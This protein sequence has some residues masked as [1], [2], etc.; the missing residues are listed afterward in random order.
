[1]KPIVMSCDTSG[2]RIPQPYLRVY[3]FTRVVF[4]VSSSPFLLSATI[5]FHLEKYL[6]TSECLVRHLLHSTYVDDILSGG[7][8]KDEAFN[9]YTA[10]KIFCEEGF[11]LRKFLTNSKHLQVRINLQEGPNPDNSPLQD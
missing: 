3:R 6:E 1:M 2:W 8:T 7:P 5:R 4:G 10:S 11:N 9:L